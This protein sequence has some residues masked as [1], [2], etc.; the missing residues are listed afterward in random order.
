[1]HSLLRVPIR[2]EGELVGMLAFFSKQVGA[3]TQDDAILAKRIAS[4]VALVISRQRL[5]DESQ[6]RAALQE[7][8]AN[9][10]MLDGLLKTL[11]GVL[12]IRQVFARVSEISQRVL[13]HD[14]VAIGEVM[15]GGESIRMYASQGLGAGPTPAIPR[16]QNAR[17]DA[18]PG[19]H[20]GPRA[21]ARLGL[22]LRSR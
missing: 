14:A 15:P 16:R 4:H 6:R 8:Q 13:P 11:T 17:D 10:E 2:L 22:G 20:P 21:P 7:R 12:D 5:G 18:I 3:Y 19:R 9:L 1:M